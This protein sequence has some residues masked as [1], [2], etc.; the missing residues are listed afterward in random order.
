M[1]TT[2]LNQLPE[3]KKPKMFGSKEFSSL[4]SK[5]EGRMVNR[6]TEREPLIDG[7]CIPA[8][9]K[10][11]GAI[12]FLP[13]WTCSY[14]YFCRNLY[15]FVEQGYSVFALNS[16]GV[17]KTEFG[18]LTVLSF[19]KNYANDIR[20]FLD[21]VE[22]SKGT[23][24][25][26]VAH[27]MG[28]M[29]AMFF[30]KDFASELDIKTLSL[31]APALQSPIDSLPN[32]F[33]S[34]LTKFSLFLFEWNMAGEKE[35]EYIPWSTRGLTKLLA[36]TS[37]A[38]AEFRLLSNESIVRRAHKE[39]WK[40][41]LT[42]DT[43]TVCIALGS[44]IHYGNEVR[45]LMERIKIPMLIILGQDDVFVGSEML[46]MQEDSTEMVIVDGASHFPHFERPNEVNNRIL[47]FIR[48][49]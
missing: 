13:G 32:G 49:H 43:N 44:M 5:L 35:K 10:E 40:H 38:L 46:K 6:R 25:H 45:D 27:S 12:L 42:L 19:M 2:K 8:R 37:R 21:R 16:P 36:R 28:A 3:Q 15:Y 20:T 30:I 24:I 39:F 29:A 9:N 17:G 31:I 1:L 22:L 34:L 33:F 41:L 18:G 11:K 23:P 47:N 48:G 4:L 7:F 26:V 14:E